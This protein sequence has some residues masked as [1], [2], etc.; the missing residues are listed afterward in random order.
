MT[1]SNLIARR[2]GIAV[3]Q[4]PR[5]VE[6]AGYLADETVFDA[7][8]GGVEAAVARSG[9]T[10]PVYICHSLGCFIG[11]DAAS[12]ERGACVIAINMPASP[13][14]GFR[15]ACGAAARMTGIASM[16]G[17]DEANHYR[18][19]WIYFG[20]SRTDDLVRQRLKQIHRQT[21][22]YRTPRRRDTTLFLKSVM[23]EHMQKGPH[24]P[25]VLVV[26]GDC[27]PIA[28]VRDA[29]L[30][31]K[32]LPNSVLVTIRGAHVLPVTHPR[33]IVREVEGFLARG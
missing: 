17:I 19:S 26:Q 9:V 5:I 3:H 23:L 32:R 33:E 27:D 14:H 15:R 29:A 4:V 24:M 25:R 6:R 1:T 31:R 18:D 30:L 7:I 11:L 28:P 13:W 8:R 12:R 20:R 22:C 10:A 21:H 2:A 16:R